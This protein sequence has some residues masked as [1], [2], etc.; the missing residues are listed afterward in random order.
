MT[1]ITGLTDQ[2]KQQSTVV[3]PDGSQ[4][5]LFLEYRQQQAGWFLDVAW[6]LFEVNGLRLTASP[7]YL[8]KWQNLLPFGLSV[9][10]K[11]DVEPTTITDF[12]DGTVTLLLLTTED[13]AAVNVVAYPGN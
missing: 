9:L 1:T 5:S 2:P 8:R 6:Q 11:D 13:I 4:V 7:N 3:L 12:V 10:T